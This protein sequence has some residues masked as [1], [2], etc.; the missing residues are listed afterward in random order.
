MISCWLCRDLAKRGALK[1]GE[2]ECKMCRELTG[3]TGKK[4]DE[5]LLE[6]EEE[7]ED[8]CLHYAT[9]L[10]LEKPDVEAAK[11]LA[12]LILAFRLAGKLLGAK[13]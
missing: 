1:I 10:G 5:M 4:V 7:V 2:A 12:A 3:W 9:E 11:R 8:I 6:I 13:A